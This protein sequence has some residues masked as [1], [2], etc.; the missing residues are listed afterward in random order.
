MST[1]NGAGVIAHVAYVSH[2]VWV[3]ENSSAAGA[4]SF[5][6]IMDAATG[7]HI[8]R[9]PFGWVEV[10]SML[11]TGKAANVVTSG[12]TVSDHSIV[13]AIAT[14]VHNYVELI[15]TA[16]SLDD[17]QITSGSYVN[18]VSKVMYLGTT[19]SIYPVVAILDGVSR[20]VHSYTY[21]SI[22]MHS[23]SLLRVSSPPNFIGGFVAGTCVSTASVNFI[24]AGMVR[25]DS[26]VMTGMYLAPVRGSIVN[27]GE[28]VNTMALEHLGP[29]S[30][31]AGGLQLSDGTGMQAYLLR[32]NVLYRRF[33]YGM[34]Y[35]M[36]NGASG[37]RRALLGDIKRYEGIK[38]MVQVDKS[39]Y[40]LVNNKQPVA[41]NGR[42]S[43]SVLETD[44]I[45]G[46]IINQVHIYSLNASIQCS[47][48]AAVSNSLL[49]N[50][51][52][53]CEVRTVGNVTQSIVL[54]VDKELTASK[55]PVGFLR[56]D[57][58]LFSAEPVSFKATPLLFTVTGDVIRTS[59][60]TFSTVDGSS[61]FHP[62]KTPTSQ[63][64]IQPSSAP[65]GQP[66]SS[67]TTAPS[68][69]PQPTSQP[70]S[71][72]PTNSNKPTVQFTLPPTILPNVNPS[73][74]PS[75]Q[76]T[77]RAT[78]QPT[79]TP[80]I[81]PSIIPSATPSTIKLTLQPSC[82]PTRHPTVRSTLK[83]TQLPSTETTT[84]GSSA[85]GDRI[86]RARESTILGYSVAGL[87]VLWLLYQLC[88]WCQYKT[89]KVMEDKKRVREMLAQGLPGKPR[90][91]IFSVAVELCCLMKS[92]CVGE[93]TQGES[94]AVAVTSPAI[95]ATDIAGPV[96]SGQG[97]FMDGSCHFV[98]LESNMPE[99]GDAATTA[100]NS[101]E[102]NT[103]QEKEERESAHNARVSSRTEGRIVATPTKDAEGTEPSDL[104]EVS[105]VSEE[106]EDG[107]DSSSEKEEKEK[108]IFVPKESACASVD[109][110]SDSLPSDDSDVVYTLSSDTG[111][112]VGGEENNTVSFCGE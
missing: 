60:Y 106:S 61:T 101:G 77:V 7:A 48:I 74:K 30:F 93:D 44:M 52:I 102:I 54:S 6:I 29:D 2:A 96:Y 69:S 19:K 76:P 111:F 40:M 43:L 39:L 32:V 4:G 33:I 98:D 68:V 10:T 85:T 21:T 65:S 18:F 49:S 9:F 62:S 34:R 35:S 1:F 79:K 47:D 57:Y 37:N 82:K 86:Y 45:T 95:V 81:S 11:Q 46:S 78:Q 72:S 22:M 13:S 24:L 104:S 84:S 103:R 59:E 12:Y 89:K 50:L 87:L 73:N 71:S 42:N 5:C 36:H 109:S 41:A 92:K 14:C 110:D 23:I 107:S 90:Y 15:C 25:T 108:D 26:G 3:C 38:A 88:R 63:P 51:V 27:N 99:G 100:Q 75:V 83:P 80:T 56:V 105:S 97:A 20:R 66:S 58:D 64:S 16:T 53:V 8:V 70:S 17:T 55:L 112:E 67:P 31:I 91:P 94:A 28:L